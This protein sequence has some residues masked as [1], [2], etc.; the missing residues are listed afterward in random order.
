MEI[1]ADLKNLN[2][3]VHR[4]IGRNVMLFQQ[5]EH[6]LKSILINQ[7]LSFNITKDGYTHNLDERKSVFSKQTMGQIAKQYID[8]AFSN[9]K[10]SIS[11]QTN[12]ETPGIIIKF[13]ATTFDDSDYYDQR[14]NELASIVAERNDLIHHLLPKWNTESYESG[15]DTELYLDEQ[16]DRVMPEIDLLKSIIQSM[17]ESRKEFAE[18]LLSDE[19]WKELELLSLR[20]S[21]H[22]AGLLKF[23]TTKKRN[24][25]WVLLSG[26]GSFIHQSI[27][28]NLLMEELA[29][30]RKKYR[31]KTLKEI[32]EKSEYFDLW[33]KPIEK[34]GT[35]ILY[36]IKPD[37]GI[38]INYN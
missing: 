20:N 9:T 5:I 37:L 27:S 23:A 2:K 38:E 33:D 6:M 25:G 21:Q 12:D 3:E 17:K 34:G 16:R 14:K 11:D 19:C 31:C 28:E 30:I 4:K 29:F 15:R 7:N 36:R 35:Q 32:A 1:D 8:T 18:Y 26:A 24:D 13:G 10:S 22:I